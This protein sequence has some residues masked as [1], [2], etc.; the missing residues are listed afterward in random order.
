ML[1]VLVGSEFNLTSSSSWTLGFN[2]L[3]LLSA[4]LANTGHALLE[5]LDNCASLLF[6]CE[7]QLICLDKCTHMLCV[8]SKE[9]DFCLCIGMGNC[10][11]SYCTVCSFFGLF[12]ELELL[13]F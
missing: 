13:A 11:A 2:T 4:S 5:L 7:A 9:H 6:R 10:W 3:K 1:S 8:Q 12:D